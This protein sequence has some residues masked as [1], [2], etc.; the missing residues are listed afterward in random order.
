[1]KYLFLIIGFC[2]TCSLSA[3]SM[4]ASEVDRLLKQEIEHIHKDMSYKGE[5]VALSNNQVAKLKKLLKV[6]AERLH[7]L[8]NARM[9]KREVSSKIDALNKEFDPA[10]MEILQPEQKRAYLASPRNKKRLAS[11]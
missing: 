5:G 9:D 8:R 11:Q 7:T 10:I 2:F 3:Q 4:Q 1:M 6:K